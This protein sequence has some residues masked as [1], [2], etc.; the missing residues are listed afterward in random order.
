MGGSGRLV[1]LPPGN[2]LSWIVD[3]L[4]VL[5]QHQSERYGEEESHLPCRESNAD[6]PC[7][8]TVYID[9]AI[10]ETTSTSWML[11]WP[12]KQHGRTSLPRW[13]LQ[14]SQFEWRLRGRQTLHPSF[15]LLSSSWS[16]AACD[17]SRGGGD[18]KMAVPGNADQFNTRS[19]SICI[20]QASMT[21]RVWE[22]L[23]W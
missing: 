12:L 9:W 18:S 13:N 3:L 20:H 15:S 6:L 2:T 22:C 7:P 19:S 23:N 17:R 5:P 1:S 16:A 4:S 10:P 11:S 14:S 21:S 8:L